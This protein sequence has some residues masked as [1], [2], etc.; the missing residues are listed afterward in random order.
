[1][2]IRK[3]KKLIE[4]LEQSGIDELEI[5]EGDDAVRICR[6]SQSQATVQTVAAQ[7]AVAPVAPSAPSVEAD[8]DGEDSYAGHVVTS[9]MVGTF[10]RSPKPDAPAF[11]EIGQRVSVGDVLCTIEA[12]KMFNQIESDQSGVITQILAENGR[13]VEFGQ[14]LFVIEED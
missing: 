12:M 7:P 14:A 6:Y 11:V 13:G 4:L 3:V 8:D 2:D 10:Y 1:M 5:K 9:P